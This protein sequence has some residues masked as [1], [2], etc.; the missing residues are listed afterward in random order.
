MLHNLFYRDYFGQNKPGFYADIGAFHPDVF[1][2]T[3]YFYKHNWK[4]INVDGNRESITLFEEQ[5]KRDIN[6]HSIISNVEKEYYFPTKMSEMNSI[7]N[8]KDGCEKVLSQ[9][10]S[11]L[12]D[13]YTSDNQVINFM[14]IDVE[15]DDLEVLKSNNWN[16]YRPN[17]LLVE[18]EGKTILETLESEIAKY[19]N[20]QDYK[21]VARSYIVSHIG[22][23][24]FI[25][26]RTNLP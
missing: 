10:L 4:G 16:K 6:V 15:G 23:A 21:S 13:R 11:S 9:T 5:R 14:S 18:I 12:L 1:S 22:T 24:V 20:S 2:N 17:V 19:L 26:N 7:S 8:T 3:S 25:D